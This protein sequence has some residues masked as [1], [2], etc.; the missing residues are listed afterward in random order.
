MNDFNVHIADKEIVN[1]SDFANAWDV[2][3]D[4]VN[5][6]VKIV[7]SFF[8]QDDEF[9]QAQGMTNTG[10][11]TEFN[12]VVVDKLRDNNFNPIACVTSRYGT[13][14]TSSV[15]EDMRSQMDSL[16]EKYSLDR[17]YVSGDGG[18]QS[19]SIFMNDMVGLSGI[20]DDVLMEI[21]LN[22]SVDGSKAHSMGLYVRN[23]TGDTSM[24]VYGGAYKLSARHT[25][26]IVERTVDFIPSINSMIENWNE[27]II[28][29]MMVMFDSKYDREFAEEL[30]DQLSEDAGIGKRHRD[31]IKALYVSDQVRTN[32]GSDSLYRVNAAI[33]QY[34]EDEL[35]DKRELQDRFLDGLSKA[36]SKQI[37]KHQ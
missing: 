26:T 21:R 33:T 19:L 6:P 11:P 20:P 29:M 17:L 37:K 3:I 13:V 15:Y 27:N 16:D 32:D 5:Y 7:P 9:V 12:F 31:N 23:K 34:I 8:K 10:R 2:A 35:D 14:N 18:T 25:N 30:V 4:V 36:V 28:P 24:A 1:L 22:T